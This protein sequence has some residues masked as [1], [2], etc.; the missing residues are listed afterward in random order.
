MLVGE[1][2]GIS[3]LLYCTTSEHM[4]SSAYT[5]TSTPYTRPLSQGEIH[6]YLKMEIRKEAKKAAEVQKFLMPEA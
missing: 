6:L 2:A 5:S 3:Q 4:R 1:K